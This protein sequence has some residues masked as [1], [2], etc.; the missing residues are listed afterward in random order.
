M[1][2]SKKYW[3]YLTGQ[4]DKSVRMMW[5]NFLRI[6]G[7][8]LSETKW[9]FEA[10]HFC[11]NEKDANELVQLVLEGK[12]RG[13]A[14][15]YILYQIENERIPCVGDLSILTDW[16][17]KA[18]CIIKNKNVS[19]L[20]FKEI[21]TEHARIEGEGDKSLEYWRRAHRSVFKRETDRMGIEF[22]EEL[23]VVFEEFEIVYL[24]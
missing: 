21:L 15:L 20:P 17:G 23:L 22:N 12:K 2:N 24:I 3:R 10:W 6:N 5:E 8:N 16:D 13:T 14:S 11:D 4:M 9:K 18:K 7:E 1:F 19:V